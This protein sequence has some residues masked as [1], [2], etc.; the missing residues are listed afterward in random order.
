MKNISILG[1]TGYV[2]LEL[3]RLLSAHPEVRIAH[4]VSS[5]AAG[6]SLGNIYPSLQ[7]IK[8]PQ[9]ES[10]DMETVSADSDMVFT[11][12]PHGE[13]QQAV[14]ALREQGA[15]VIDM[16]GDFRY[17]DPFIYAAWY[18]R[19]D[20]PDLLS[21]SVYGMPE[22]YRMYLGK[23]DLIGNPGCYTTASILALAPLVE[24]GV[25]DTSTIIIDA[26]SGASGAGRK[27]SQALH[28]CEVEGDAKAYAVGTHRHT[29]EIEQE[30]SKLARQDVTVSFTPHLLPIK[31]GILATSYAKLAP[32][33]D[34]NSI[35]EIYAEAYDAEPFVQVYEQG[36][37]P[38]LKHVVGSNRLA[39]GFTV[40]LRTQRIV[41]V[42]CLDNLIKGAAGQAVQNFNIRFGFDER[43]GLESLPWYL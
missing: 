25:I 36:Q 23:A 37:L 43:A 24:S 4:L 40:D 20:Y 8:L 10:L 22:L 30:L 9:L 17:D 12:L 16:S 1:A 33:Q 38:Q 11:A 14:A 13:S 34:G 7:S 5:T 18:S 21:E 19:H 32:G 27:P 28:F 6:Q 39:V 31:R 29:S 41:V 42:S 3:T 15:R 26:K 2:G 35:R